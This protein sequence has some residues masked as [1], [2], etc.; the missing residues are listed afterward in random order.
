MLMFGAFN[1]SAQQS[2]K[3]EAQQS[4]GIEKQ[5]VKVKKNKATLKAAQPKTSI[6]SEKRVVQ[7]ARVE[8][9]KVEPIKK[10]EDQ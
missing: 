10:E 7:K 1:A 9:K 3:N 5:E 4:E 8:K 2:E 6:S